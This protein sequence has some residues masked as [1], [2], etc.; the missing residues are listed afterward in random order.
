MEDVDLLWEYA[1]A[2]S[3]AAF[4]ILVKRY[5]PLVYSAAIRQVV[6]PAV[7]ED[8]TQA[9]FIILA[10]KASNI[11]KGTVLPAWL[12]QTTHY[13]AAKVLRSEQRRRRREQEAVRMQSLD[14]SSPWEQI[15][16]FLD[17]A[18]AQLSEVDRG[19]V[20]LR[21]F[22]NKG[23][24]DVGRVYGMSEDA[25]QKRVA[26]AVEKLRRILLRL[27]VAIPAVAITGLLSTHAAQIAPASL[28]TLVAAAALQK[29]A[30]S[31]SVYALLQ[32]AFQE[33]I[34]PRIA[35]VLS[36]GLA[37]VAVAIALVILWPRATQSSFSYSFETRVV[38]HP[39]LAATV[40]LTEPDPPAPITSNVLVV[41]VISNQPPQTVRF[42]PKDAKPMLAR[43]AVFTNVPVLVPDTLDLS[44]RLPENAGQVAG[45]QAMY[46]PAYG[47]QPFY[48]R[49]VFQNSVFAPGLVGQRMVFSN[50]LPWQPVQP[51]G[52]AISSPKA[53]R[54][55]PAGKR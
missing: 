49:P 34:W 12:Y 9:V 13:I 3:E 16:P 36:A 41:P 53:S 33:S 47:A 48:Q 2:K 22:Q 7:A 31:T 19:V 55:K 50:S 37:V 27:G 23:L 4:H 38:T 42:A 30:M 43:S 32:G 14:L 29:T 40:A 8:V 10:R 54:S 28:P 15:A 24:R 5:V 21:Y 18:M 52:R 25:A 51:A 1:E 46:M 11:S 44:A 6:E 35:P 45:E 20:L 26:R 39:Q 17:E